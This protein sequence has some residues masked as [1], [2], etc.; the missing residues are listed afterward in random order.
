MHKNRL[1]AWVVAGSAFSTACGNAPL[2]T[3]ATTS[4]TTTTTAVDRDAGTCGDEGVARLYRITSL[5]IPD[6]NQ[7]WDGGVV[8]QNVD[9]AGTT[10]RIVDYAGGVDNSVA[11]LVPVIPDL[12][13]GF[14]LQADIDSRLGCASTAVGCERLDM[15]LRVA[16]GPDCASMRLEDR[17]G[18]ALTETL[19]AS[20]D[21]DGTI[22]GTVPVATWDITIYHSRFSITVRDIIISAS[23][24]NDMVSN[25]VIGGAIDGESVVNSIR[26][27]LHDFSIVDISYDDLAAIVSLFLDVEVDGECAAVSVGMLAAAEAYSE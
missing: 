7:A 9:D 12:I 23:I 19:H 18:H 1:I 22:R 10:C 15:I 20:L 4:T 3:D 13:P 2:G 6:I 14:D 21:G 25:I 16:T 5:V 17:D 24:S 11:H 26:T 27:L 8:G